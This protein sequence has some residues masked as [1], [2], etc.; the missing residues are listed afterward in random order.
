VKEVCTI[1]VCSLSRLAGF[2][3]LSP[4]RFSADQEHAFSEFGPD[5]QFRIIF[6]FPAQA[7]N[8][9]FRQSLFTPIF[10]DGL[11]INPDALFKKIC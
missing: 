11:A 1:A 6:R 3:K 2:A 9:E 8:K 10:H 4:V 5:L 7:D